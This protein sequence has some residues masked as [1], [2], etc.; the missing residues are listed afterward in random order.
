M[1]KGVWEIRLTCW[2]RG[3]LLTPNLQVELFMFG[4]RTG[5]T[6]GQAADGVFDFFAELR[7][8]SGFAEQLAGDIE[9]GHDG[10][11]INA[12]NFAAVL[13]V[14][15]G[16]I[17]VFGGS[18]QGID[19]VF[20]TANLIFLVEDSHANSCHGLFHSR[21]VLL[22]RFQARDHGFDPALRQLVLLNEFCALGAPV[23]LLHAQ[24]FIFTAEHGAQ[25]DELIRSLT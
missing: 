15:H 17:K 10:N 13:D 11:A 9:R 1:R 22:E 2:Q 14:A 23:A 16:S 3:W 5:Q 6:L 18:S 25:L 20:G 7:I 19:F 4:K 24:S 21:L 12:D 8:G